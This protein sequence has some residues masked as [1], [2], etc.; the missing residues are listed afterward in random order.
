MAD[1][2]QDII[3]VTCDISCAEA[4]ARSLLPRDFRVIAAAS[5]QETLALLGTI[6]GPAIVIMDADPG[7]PFMEEPE[8]IHALS[9]HPA[10]P[11]IFLSRRLT[12]EAAEKLEHFSYY[13]H[14]DK[15][16]GDAALVSAISLALRLHGSHGQLKK[17]QRFLERAQE[18][19][20]IGCWEFLLREGTGWASPGAMALYGLDG[21]SFIIPEVQR[22][23]L[24]E[25]RTSLDDALHGLVE[26]GEPYDIE[27]QIRRLTD[28]KI[29][30]LHSQAEF[31]VSEMKVFGIIQDITTRRETENVLR[32]SEERFRHLI[33][34]T[35]D[36]IWETDSRG[37]FV[38]MSPQVES[39]LGYTPSELVGRSPHDFLLPGEVEPNRAAFDRAVREK[40]A[41]L[42]YAS[43]W[44]HRDGRI[45]TL[46]SRCT[47]KWN[48]DGSFAG[49]RGIDR[50]ITEQMKAQQRLSEALAEKQG[51]L[52]E[53]YH[54]VKNNMAMIAG[55]VRLEQDRA[56]DC[57][58][59]E[60]L[61]GL[62]G[63]IVTLAKLWDLLGITG[64]AQK[65]RLDEYLCQIATSLIDSQAGENERIRL[66][67]ALE[68]VEIDAPKAAT[69]GLIV[70]ELVTNALKHAFPGDS[71]GTISITLAGNGKVLLLRVE[72][73]GRGLP[74]DFDIS[75][76]E[77]L[78]MSLI[79][80]LS[81]QVDGTVVQVKSENT[82]FEIRVP[83]DS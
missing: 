26:R 72:D 61:E 34:A 38:Y 44:R 53:L 19:A 22:V 57:G 51:L 27:F 45:V 10:V 23:P 43:K 11:L 79:S 2:I 24:P 20:G 55:L 76:N 58:S 30:H 54:R 13:G 25:Y 64:S 75:R 33:T 37:C 68:H 82:V 69:I 14:I 6:P 9:R 8:M 78:G 50:D 65:V 83:L 73:N 80:M 21:S 71:H 28:G 47:L 66:A 70:N 18:M 56:A 81:A 48:R 5:L 40:P 36:L 31:S 12:A 1:R 4:M 62:R 77:G 63:R 49:F 29:L 59:Q 39:L 32:E 52:R 7:S 46:E 41:T 60:V 16:S 42:T 15:D 35:A 67:T 74:G 3:L 17:N